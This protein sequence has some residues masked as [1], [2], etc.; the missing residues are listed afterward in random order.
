[1]NFHC[2]SEQ[3][4]YDV[5]LAIQPGIIVTIMDPNG[6]GKSTIARLILGFYRPQDGCLYAYG[7][8]ENRLGST[9]ENEIGQDQQESRQQKDSETQSSIDQP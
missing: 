3:I 2:A 8:P 4:L 6:A 5:N 1:V 7:H 9:S